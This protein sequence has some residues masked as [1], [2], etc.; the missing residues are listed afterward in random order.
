MTAIQ[1]PLLSKA[2]ISGD[3]DRTPASTCSDRPRQKPPREIR[4][5]V[6]KLGLRYR[7]S[8]QA[9][10]EA[11]AATIALLACDLADVPPRYLERAINQHVT[12]SPFMPKASELMALV[13][14]LQDSEGRRSDTPLA[15]RWNAA[16]AAEGRHDI[17][18]RDDNGQMKLESTRR[19]GA[20]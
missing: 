20:Q 5:L 15:D 17:R 13:Q 9:D 11:H 6:A 10:L 1:N 16:L 18:W 7:P 3:R 19:Y 2:I 8:A 12:Q 14:Q 4:E